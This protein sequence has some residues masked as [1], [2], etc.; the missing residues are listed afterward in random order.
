VDG[1]EHFWSAPVSRGGVGAENR[2]MGV[3]ALTVVVAVLG[4]LIMGLLALLEWVAVV[5]PRGEWTVR[6]VYGGD[7]SATDARAYSR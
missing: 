3:R 6:N 1:C 2:P 7:H 4:L 5:R